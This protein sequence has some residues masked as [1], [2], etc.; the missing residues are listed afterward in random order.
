MSQPIDHQKA[1]GMFNDALNEMKSSL[2]KL[3]D[4][5]LKGSKKDLEKTMHSMYEELEESIQHF[6]KTNSQDHFRQAIYKLEVVKPAFILN[7]N[8]LLD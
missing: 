3:G 8:E 1:M 7:Y 6:D 5:R 4:M 2:T